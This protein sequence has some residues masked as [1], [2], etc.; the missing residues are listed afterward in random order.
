[1]ND[2][3]RIWLEF[4][5]ENLQSAEILLKSY[6][7]NPCLQNIQQSVEKSLKSVFVQNG[8]KLKKTHSITELQNSLKKNG[9]FLDL[10][11]DDCE[12]L[13]S[14]YIPSK[15]PVSSLLPHFEPNQHICEKGINIA[16]RVLSEVKS[17]LK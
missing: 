16:R 13:D 12:F 2:E 8:I 9:F 5:K 10:T 1:M 7:Y 14:I 3:S 15:Y 17:L 6:L 11:A 4:A